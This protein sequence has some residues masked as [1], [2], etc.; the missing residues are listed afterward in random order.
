V[1]SMTKP[2]RLNGR[3]RCFAAAQHDK[4]CVCDMGSFGVWMGG[5]DASLR[6]V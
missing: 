1:F 2:G 5:R 4:Q 6:L 3:E